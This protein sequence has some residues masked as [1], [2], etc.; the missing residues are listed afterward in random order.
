LV[1]RKRSFNLQRQNPLSLYC[2]LV[3]AGGLAPDHAGRLA[4]VDHLPAS[5]ALKSAQ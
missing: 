1:E 5:F 4:G 2:F 3:A